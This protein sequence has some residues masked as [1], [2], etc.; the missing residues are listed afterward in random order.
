MEGGGCVEGAGEEGKG[1]V[2]VSAGSGENALQ[3]G[4]VRVFVE[5]MNVLVDDMPE[6]GES[7]AAAEGDEEF[8]ERPPLG[9][10]EGGRRKSL[11]LRLLSAIAAV[12]V[13]TV[14]AAVAAGDDAG[15]AAPL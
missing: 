9:E 5:G 13:V 4:G 7:G 2:G 15:G 3:Q 10:Q 1:V 8:V 14:V 12:T 6:E 11:L